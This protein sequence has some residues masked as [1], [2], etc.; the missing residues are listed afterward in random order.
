MFSF[1]D[2]KLV[3]NCKSAATR[4]QQTALEL[5]R[6]GITD[7]QRFEA[8]PDIGSHESFNRSV[9]QMLRLFHISGKKHF[10]LLEDDVVFVQDTLLLHAVMSCAVSEL[11]P[12]W[13][14]LYLGANIQE[15]G[16]KTPHFHTTHLY[17]I[18]NAWTTHAVAFNQKCVERL[19]EGQPGF[20]ERM[21][22]NWLS[23]QLNALNAF[24]VAPMVAFQRPGESL[25][26]KGP[27]NYTDIFTKSNELLKTET[28]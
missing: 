23:D 16:F 17:R 4:W 15:K 22:D 8:I 1:F 19:L 6:V 9:N 12:D 7:Y 3:L 10:L 28:K 2:F 24:C 20:S 26:W 21:F 5:D 13:D 27:A 18:F 25:I 11:P 14:I